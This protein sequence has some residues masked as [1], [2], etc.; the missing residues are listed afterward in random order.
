MLNFQQQAFVNC[1]PCEYHTT[2]ILSNTLTVL[3]TPKAPTPSTRPLPNIKV[4]VSI[5]PQLFHAFAPK[6]LYRP[7]TTTPRLKRER[8]RKRTR[9]HHNLNHHQYATASFSTPPPPLQQ[10]WPGMVGARAAVGDSWKRSAVGGGSVCCLW[11]PPARSYS[12]YLCPF[13]CRYFWRVLL[14]LNPLL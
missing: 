13:S 6:H 4:N 3:A 10:V 7:P 5:L 8:E 2:P 14:H 9:Y 11:K 1:I 12:V